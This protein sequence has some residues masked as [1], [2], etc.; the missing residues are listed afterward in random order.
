MPTMS[1]P[2]LA[3]PVSP[4]NLA[5]ATDI[6]RSPAY[7]ALGWAKVPAEPKSDSTEYPRTD[8]QIDKELADSFPTS[9]PPSSWAGPAY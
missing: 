7:D 6:E 2:L 8:A 5:Q 1:R 3:S 4:R 9:H